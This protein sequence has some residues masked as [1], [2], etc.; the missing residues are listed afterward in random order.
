MKKLALGALFVG[1][2]ACGGG[3]GNTVNLIDSAVGDGG[4]VLTCNPLTQTGCQPTEKCTWIDDQDNPPIGHVGCAPDGNIALGAACPAT[5]AGP[6]GWDACVKGTVCLSGECKQICDV[7]GGA[8]TCDENH[9][10]T[11]YADFFESG[12]TAVAGVCDPACDPLTQ[13]LKIGANKA[14]CG[15]PTPAMP[16]KG[17]YGYDEYSCAPT[18]MN[19][20]P[21]TDRA[22]PQTNAAGNP[23]LNGCG[24]GFI[25][26]FFEMTGSTR[27]LCS[28]FCSALETDN[29]Q[30][31]MGNGL[32]NP[33]ALGK[34]PTAPMAIA[35]DAVCSAAKK[36]SRPSSRCKF[37]WPYL[38]DDSTGE[39]P[40]SFDQSIYRDTL[41]VCMAIE[42][43][44]YDRD[45]DMSATDDYPECNALVPNGA[46]NMYDNASFW[47]CLK[48]EN[49]PAFT[50]S[51]KRK[52]APAL[53]DVRMPKQTE[54]ELVRHNLN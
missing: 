4:M 9:S 35:G 23:Y 41:G 40:L 12:G 42:Y 38:E 43:F 51:G 53:N 15:S 20:W 10:C 16:N 3:S 6:M 22:M 49:T 34:L 32:G 27:T 52:L 50:S 47:G 48:R 31:N 36:G 17:C 18:G 26:L 5:V 39:L 19:G 2:A 29:T 54:M 30:P 28:G 24:P 14:A 8:P 13:D 1:L 46:A 25:P 7:N 45:G 21:L 44:K 11:R 37:M 33:D